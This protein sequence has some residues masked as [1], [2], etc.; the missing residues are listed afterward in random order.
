[1]S[2]YVWY[3]GDW[4]ELDL[5]AP[6]QPSVGPMIIRDIDPYR[7]MATGERIRSRRHHRDHLRAHRL[8]EVGNEYSKGLPIDSAPESRAMTT[9]GRRDA[10]ERAIAQV[11][12]GGAR[13]AV[14][15]EG[16]DL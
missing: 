16:D 1:M 9:A 11:E 14:G 3:R 13:K 15:S 6:R 8:V 7:S 2:R 12:Q 5:N 10:I 4:R